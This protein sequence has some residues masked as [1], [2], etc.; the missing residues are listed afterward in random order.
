MLFLQTFA[1]GPPF[2]THLMALLEVDK[3]RFFG[4]VCR[5]VETRGGFYMGVLCTNP[6]LRDS[7]VCHLCAGVALSPFMEP[8]ATN[9]A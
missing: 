7:A 4:T 2:R 6:R 8:L 5:C 3:W 1:K 9:K